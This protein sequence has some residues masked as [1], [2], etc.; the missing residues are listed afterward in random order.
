VDKYTADGFAV[1][2]SDLLEWLRE[3]QFFLNSSELQEIRLL[4]ETTGARAG[5]A[6]ARIRELVLAVTSRQVAGEG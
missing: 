4:S 1:S 5:T 6:I 2:S 3:S